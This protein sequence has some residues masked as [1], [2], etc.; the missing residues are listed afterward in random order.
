M[1]NS[2]KNNIFIIAAENSAE[3][4]ASMIVEEFKKN[5]SKYN[6]FGIG[7]DK[8]KKSGADIIFNSKKL[9]VVG[10][11][12]VISSLFKLHKLM[13][14]IIKE[15]K[16]R[17]CSTAI[18][19]DYP[20]FNL[21]LAKKL[22]QSGVSVYFYIS[23]TV[24]AWRY[25]RVDL[26]K[27]YIK[28]IFLIFP[29]EKDIYEREKI[30]YTY[31]GHPIA[32]KVKPTEPKAQIIKNENIKK[33]ENIITLLPGSRI[34]EINFLLRP[35]LESLIILKKEKIIRIFLILAN[36]IKK[37]TIDNI[38]KNYPSLEISVYA[39]EHGYSIIN[40]SDLVISKSGTSNLEI[41][42]LKI[43]FISIYKVN[44]MSY[45]LG[46]RFLKIN[47]Y[48]IVNIL[49]KKKAVTELIQDDMT[50]EN[51]YL[52]SKKILDDKNF[53]K[54]MIDEF[55]KLQSSLTLPQSPETIIYN[56]ITTELEKNDKLKGT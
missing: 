4:Y 28:R 46:K 52:E 24:W 33:N 56:T 5:N 3:K 34:S 12:E 20:D 16:K 44:K 41:A 18:L 47:L 10:I 19:I 37:E 43:P 11:I 49:L 50:A 13:K 25:S 6:F 27:K 42:L 39:Q 17:K 40:A 48:S 54:N 38:L 15:V 31:T 55:K 7:G 30:P 51:I 26:I 9:S 53:V 23:P 21:R 29:F 36:N 14:F 22:K 45:F 2:T 1:S 35:I 8:L 32:S